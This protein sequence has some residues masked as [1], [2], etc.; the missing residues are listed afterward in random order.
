MTTSISTL[1]LYKLSILQCSQMQTINIIYYFP[2]S[3]TY[4]TESFYIILTLHGISSIIYIVY[5][6]YKDRKTFSFILGFFF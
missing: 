6:T 5:S 3:F 1:F 2:Y 4:L